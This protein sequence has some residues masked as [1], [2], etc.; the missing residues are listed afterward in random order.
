MKL[1][2]LSFAFLLLILVGCAT[3]PMDAVPDQA[4]QKPSAN[5]SQ[6][7]FMR[8]SFI[9]SAIAATLYEVRD[10]KTEFIGILNN[11][12][13][14][15]LKTT[16]GKHLYM[17]V[18]EVADFMEADLSPGKTHY[19]MIT[20][21]MGAWKARFSMWPISTNPSAE[22]NTSSD[23]F[24]EWLSET[25]L[26]TM[27]ESALAW[28]QQN[29]ASVEQKRV[30]YWPKWQQKTPEDKAKRTLVPSDGL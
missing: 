11:G 19:S 28:Y 26:V 27:S 23:D 25:S 29:K 17:V 21:R 20:P 18:S 9:G 2:K 5:Q 7:V 3:I 30:K 10:N 24:Q 4:I 14:I 12:T 1:I 16:P 22:F 6:V 13:K 8:S 15:A